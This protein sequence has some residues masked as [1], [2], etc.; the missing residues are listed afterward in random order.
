MK[1]YPAYKDSGVKE[2]GEI[3]EHW[4]LNSLKWL[5]SERLKYGAN[6]A[7]ELDDPNLPRY[8]RITDFS[9]NSK[10]KDDTF[11]SLPLEIAKDYL[12]NDG[13][14][15]FARSG[16]TVGKTFQFKN[17]TLESPKFSRRPTAETYNSKRRT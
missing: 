2:I 13:D 14:V 7:A 12:L 5:L 17:Y 15:L 16:A 6:E 10:L 4:S 9:T 8:I 3:P 11:K 1:R